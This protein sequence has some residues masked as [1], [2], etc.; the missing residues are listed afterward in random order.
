MPDDQAAES[1]WVS[2]PVFIHNFIQLVPSSG[3]N[4]EHRLS[5]LKV[6]PGQSY[7]EARRSLW[8]ENSAT[9]PKPRPAS[10]TK[11]ESM[12]SDPKSIRSNRVWESALGPIWK[13]IL[14][15]GRLKYRLP[16]Q[17]L[18]SPIASQSVR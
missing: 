9:E 5:N 12:V 7:Y 4:F 6:P 11:L 14:D 10:I 15:S 17:V 13:G 8:L 3:S 2:H 16:L 18:V 1:A